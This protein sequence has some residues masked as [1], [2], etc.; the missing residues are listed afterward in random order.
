[1]FRLARA[2]GYGKGDTRGADDVKGLAGAQEEDIGVSPSLVGVNRG[3]PVQTV[4]CGQNH[5]T[6]IQRSGRKSDGVCE[7][8]KQIEYTG[9]TCQ[10]APSVAVTWGRE[11]ALLQLIL[12]TTPI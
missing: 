8:D 10:K 7:R 6:K 4:H 12:A 1:V 5:A 9:S 11:A 3:I 2:R